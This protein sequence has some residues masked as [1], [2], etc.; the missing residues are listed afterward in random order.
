MLGPS[1]RMLSI[2][3]LTDAE[4][5]PWTLDVVALTVTG[6]AGQN[7]ASS[8]EG[9][10]VRSAVAGAK[11]IP[12]EPVSRNDGAGGGEAPEMVVWSNPGPSSGNAVRPAGGTLFV[13]DPMP[14]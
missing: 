7:H 8:G 12:F 1:V 2:W 3:K 9:H 10:A 4:G 11:K 5:E 6:D 13:R 14:R